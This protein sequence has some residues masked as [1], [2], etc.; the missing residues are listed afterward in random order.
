MNTLTME[1]YVLSAEELA[2]KARQKKVEEQAL[3]VAPERKPQPVLPM[4]V[5]RADPLPDIN[6]Y[7]FNRLLEDGQWGVLW[8]PSKCQSIPLVLDR[9]DRYI[10]LPDATDRESGAPQVMRE[11]NTLRFDDVN[12]NYVPL[13]GVNKSHIESV[14]HSRPAQNLSLIEPNMSHP[15]DFHR[16]HFVPSR[17]IGL[18]TSSVY[19]VTF[20][21]DKTLG[22]D[23]EIVAQS[24]YIEDRAGLSGTAGP[25]VVVEHTTDCP[26]FILNVGMGSLLITFW[27]KERASD[28]P[29]EDDD[30]PGLYVLE[31]DDPP[32][33]SAKIPRKQP[34]SSWQSKLFRAPIAKHQVPSSD[35]LLVKDRNHRRFSIRRIDGLYTAGMIEPLEVVMQPNSK[36][37]QKFQEDFM[38]AV[39]INIFRG[40]GEY[41]PRR[42]VQIPQLRQEYFPEANEPKLRKI[43]KAIASAFREEGVVGWVLKSDK[44][45]DQAFQSLD[46]TPEKVCCY[47]SMQT[48]LHRLRQSGV[49]IITSSHRLY[50]KIQRMKGERTKK[51]AERIELELM[52][53]PWSRTA[54]FHD[55]FEARPMELIDTDD[56]QQILRKKSRLKDGQTV[57]RKL[58]NT[59]GDLRKLT[60]QTLRDYLL[61]YNVPEEEIQRLSRWNMVGVLRELAT[62]DHRDD[63]TTMNF[64]RGPRNEYQAS[65]LKYKEQYQQ[66]FETNLMFISS[67][68]EA[69]GCKDLDND[70]EFPSFPMHEEEEEENSVEEGEEKTRDMISLDDP[71]E[72]QPN[73]F[74]TAPTQVDWDRYGYQDCPRRTIAKLISV[75]LADRGVDVRVTWERN[76]RRV[77]RLKEMPEVYQDHG[78]HVSG[79][80]LDISILT[81]YAKSL[82]E[83]RRRAKQAM[84][85]AADAKV[86]RHYP[87]EIERFMVVERSMDQ[88]CFVLSPGMIE[89]IR[90]ASRRFK[91]F[92]ARRKNSGGASVPK[93]KKTE[94][95]SDSEEVTVMKKRP[96]NQLS[97]L[98]LNKKLRLILEA[99]RGKSRFVRGEEFRGIEKRCVERGYYS[100]QSFRRDLAALGSD[101]VDICDREMEKMW[102]ELER[103]EASIEIVMKENKI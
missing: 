34:V 98:E 74:C 36:A 31:P 30:A 97:V 42:H 26:V 25:V 91:E 95:D 99:V 44:G 43:L 51:I 80:G 69:G 6:R 1:D 86:T 55:A 100:I 18:D 102:S 79:R 11:W 45:L 47:Q 87:R 88:Y 22:Y 78:Q 83:K 71:E 9:A 73:S 28:C 82:S 2:K 103:I 66:K 41:P 48:G 16:P 17:P 77:Q 67:S 5:Q 81:G 89:K 59:S 40:T 50:H 29:R 93:K 62:R 4:L 63:A 54:N 3:M 72:L 35:M 76:P 56:G 57:R 52:K 60:L 84:K 70:E 96:R 58:A 32:H 94:E 75:S 49:K 38:K 27:Q 8:D 21:P 53:T 12:K 92:M 10:V 19:E 85:K 37:T 64:A 65:L 24:P 61:G 68:T 14:Q 101:V 33:F 23:S 90:E 46:V 13:T 39:I 7:Y 20:T 15:E